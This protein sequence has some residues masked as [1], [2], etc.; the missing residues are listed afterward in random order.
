MTDFVL[1]HRSGGEF[2]HLEP[3]RYLRISVK[4]TGVGMDRDTLDRVFEPF[5]TTKPSGEGTG[6]GL[7]VVHGVVTSLKG[8]ISAESVKGQGSV[9]HVVLP[10]IEQTA[11]RADRAEA[12]PLPT[13]TEVVLFVD[14]EAVIARMVDRMLGSLGY[15]ATVATDPR[16]AVRLFRA[17]PAAV[18]LVITDQ[19]MPHLTGSQLAGELL[20]IRPDLP[21]VICTGF[22]EAISPQEAMDV[23]VRE[24]MLKPIA[25][26]QLAETVRRALDANVAVAETDTAEDLPVEAG[27]TASG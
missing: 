27:E 19:V 4:D 12:G 13:G 10:T 22:S 11:D 3:G 14:D 2:P 16:E 6:M 20:K 1:H 5:F 24:F 25:M 21:I 18:D 15:R 17:N 23:G 9:F 7:A 8:A 26:R